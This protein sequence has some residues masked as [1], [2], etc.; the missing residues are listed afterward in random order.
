MKRYSPFVVRGSLLLME[1][2][3]AYALVA[4]FVRHPIWPDDGAFSFGGPHR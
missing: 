1:S 4:W 2:L 3:W